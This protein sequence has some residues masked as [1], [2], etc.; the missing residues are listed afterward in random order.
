MLYKTG[1]KQYTA[2]GIIYCSICDMPDTVQ[3]PGPHFL[4]SYKPTIKPSLQVSTCSVSRGQFST[5]LFPSFGYPIDL[6]WM[7]LIKGNLISMEKLP[8]MITASNGI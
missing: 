4:F 2:H 6:V 7:K 1:T 3:L 5:F 8:D